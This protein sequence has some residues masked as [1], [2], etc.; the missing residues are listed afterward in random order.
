M[1]NHR[2]RPHREVPSLRALWLKWWVFRR[3]PEPGPRDRTA[4]AQLRDRAGHVAHV[5]S[6]TDGSLTIEGVVGPPTSVDGKQHGYTFRVGADQLRN[7]IA[8]LGGPR[9]VDLVA[10][11]VASADEILDH[12]FVSFETALERSSWGSDD[13]EDGGPGSWLR[14]HGI[15]H[16]VTNRTEPGPGEL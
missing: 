11:V 8:A 6:W 13:I 12:G 7:L 9:Y 1:G 5:C 10:T 15:V 16:S 3:L 2:A 4:T 14:E